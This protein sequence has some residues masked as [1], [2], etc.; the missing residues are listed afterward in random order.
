MAPASALPG[1]V[2]PAALLAGRREQEPPDGTRPGDEP[3]R[4][5]GEPESHAV[6]GDR[7]PSF[8]LRP[9]DAHGVHQEAMAVDPDGGACEERHPVLALDDLERGVFG[10]H[11]LDALDAIVVI[12]AEHRDPELVAH[13]RLEQVGEETGLRET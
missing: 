13:P 6:A 8:G 7:L 1:G 5:P 12:L 4:P 11:R 2:G 10:Q 9:G 3:H